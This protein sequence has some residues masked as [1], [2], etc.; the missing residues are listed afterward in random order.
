MAPWVLGIDAPGNREGQKQMK[1]R[2][3]KGRRKGIGG[4]EGDGRVGKLREKGRKTKGKR[5]GGRKVVPLI[6][7]TVIASL[8]RHKQIRIVC[9]GK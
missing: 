2:E 4:K 5:R 6:F 9:K 1:A 8:S 7:Q 3:W